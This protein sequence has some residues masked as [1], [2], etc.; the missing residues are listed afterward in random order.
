MVVIFSSPPGRVRSIVMSV[1][2]YLS[3]CPLTYLKNHTST[4]HIIFCTCYMLP[5]AVAQSS[6]DNSAKC[7]VLPV[8]W[9]A[10]RL[11]IMESQWTRI[12]ENVMFRRVRQMAAPGAKLLSTITGLF[13]FL[14]TKLLTNLDH[15]RLLRH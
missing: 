3:V 15:T 4:F 6:C 9:I 1:F 14:T 5:V 7:F 13:Q 12:K 10:S 11:Q 8:L 2:V